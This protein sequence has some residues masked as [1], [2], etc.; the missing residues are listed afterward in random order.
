MITIYD[1]SE[2]FLIV[3]LISTKKIEI[4]IDRSLWNEDILNL[5]RKRKG[6]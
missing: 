6:Q 4:M 2:R 3:C 1:L 5:I